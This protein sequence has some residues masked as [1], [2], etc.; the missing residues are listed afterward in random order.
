MNA[1]SGGWIGRCLELKSALKT[2]LDDASSTLYLFWVDLVANKVNCIRD[3]WL[4]FKIDPCWIRRDLI[5][6]STDF[7]RMES[8]GEEQC[9]NTS[10]SGGCCSAFQP[11]IIYVTL[12]LDKSYMGISFLSSFLIRSSASSKTRNRTFVTSRSPRFE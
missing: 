12:S 10:L 8:G 2:E 6:G 4:S 9:L 3:G 1:I 5:D 7:R 11:S